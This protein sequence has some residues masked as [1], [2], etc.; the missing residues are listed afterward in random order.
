MTAVSKV[1][2]N[3][4][5]LMDATTATATASEILSPYTAM[6]ADGVMTVGT[7]SGGGGSDTLNELLS[8]TLETYDT[9]EVTS[10]P[11]YAFA[12]FS[13]LKT[14]TLPNVTRLDDH[15]VA[16]S[17]V[18]TVVAPKANTFVNWRVFINAKN[19]LTIDILGAS[20]IPQQWANNCTKL[21]TLIIRKTG[22]I[23]ALGNINAFGSTPFA[24][25]G[26]G[27]TLYVPS[28][29]ISSYQSA[30]NWSTILGYANN[31]IQAIEGSIYETQY[32]DG[33]VIE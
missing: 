11:Q 18:E 33:T 30:T 4:T 22:S 15:M 16:D 19:L 29:L 2:L 20:T 24:S 32:A 3:G 9:G 23:M 7:A 21:T 6:T 5:T 8:G 1:T 28:A 10:V 17:S 31:S 27:G 25:G 13:G 26:T 14:L 12:Y